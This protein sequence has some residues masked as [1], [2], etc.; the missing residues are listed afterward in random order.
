[1]KNLRFSLSVVALASLLCFLTPASALSQDQRPI[2]RPP[3]S[4]VIEFNGK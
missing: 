4:L 2:K 1:M 3:T